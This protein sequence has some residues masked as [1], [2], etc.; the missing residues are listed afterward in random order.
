MIKYSKVNRPFKTIII[1]KKI[2]LIC[3]LFVI[4]QMAG[5]G[6]EQEKFEEERDER[7]KNSFLNS[8]RNP[9]TGEVDY[10]SVREVHSFIDKKISE[11]TKNARVSAAMPYIEWQERGPNNFAGRIQKV[12][13]DPNDPLKKKVWAGSNS[14]GLFYN[15]DIENVNSGWVATNMHDGPM[16]IIDMTFDPSN[17]QIFYVICVGG[18]YKSVDA[19]QTWSL[20]NS[21]YRGYDLLV[22]NSTEIYQATNNGLLK[23]IDGG[24]NWTIVLKPSLSIGGTFTGT[25][26]GGVNATSIERG[27][28]GTLYAAF[29]CG[30]IFK[31]SNGTVWTNILAPDNPSNGA[32]TLIAL[33]PSTSG[34]SQILYVVCGKDN[35]TG[36]FRKSTDG[37]VNWTPKTWTIG[38]Y[39]LYDNLV[40]KVHPTNP[41]TVFA[42][43]N[44]LR[45][46]LNGGDTWV[47]G[48]GTISVAGPVTQADWHDIQ[49]NPIDPSKSVI[50]NDQGVAFMQG[51]NNNSSFSGAV[52]YKNF[53]ASQV[54]WGAMRQV[55]ND[56]IFGAATQ[57][58]PSKILRGSGIGV[59]TN[60]SINEGNYIKFDDDQPNL[61]L[62]TSMINVE[63]YL[64][65]LNFS[66][67]NTCLTCGQGWAS[68]GVCRDYD[69]QSN[70][71]YG[72]LGFDPNVAGRIR[73]RKV[74]N[75]S[76]SLNSTTN[77]VSDFYIDGIFAN[78]GVSSLID[79][80]LLSLPITIKLGKTA[81]TMFISGYSPANA[82]GILYK[83]TNFTSSTPTVTRISPLTPVNTRF[84]GSPK[85]IAIG[86]TDN[87]LLITLNDN[88][89]YIETL[90]YTNDGGASWKTLK[91]MSGNNT[92]TGLPGKFGANYA[93]FNPFNYNQVILATNVGIWTCDDISLTIP[94]W[95][96]TNAKF[97]KIPTNNIEIRPSDGTIMVST[98]GRGIFTA[99][100]NTCQNDVVRND[101][102]DGGVLTIP[103]RTYIR[104]VGGNRIETNGIVNYNANTYVDLLPNFEV[105]KNGI[106]KAQIGGCN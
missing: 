100:L 63:L 80:D 24:T 70:T 53:L 101:V 16:G 56:T 42:G 45:L 72:L 46:S 65:N 51:T 52:R 19:G 97:G 93:A 18:F 26:S 76:A 102:I 98:Y 7:V 10:E 14:T 66:N 2:I 69:S 61:M 31:S 55:A 37:G 15:N 71:M 20:K 99:K 36:W 1:M 68:G 90:F 74:A 34:T 47:A 40:I 85:C 13:Y 21:A 96:I 59:A 54:H 28:D 103:S 17:T 8:F 67:S 95:E 73:L 49:F 94:R 57:D 5:F 9:A 62:Y 44:S 22:V 106:F 60:L 30:Q 86:V 27:T 105:K 43:V 41:N 78:D 3:Y 87:Q 48:L 33:A 88:S 104:G 75:I 58:Q 35:N 79:Y 82:G 81:N 83:V 77:V 38:F 50:S 39:Q 29:G 6:Q 23:S 11:N 84:Q 4:S 89:S 25:V 91:K 12:M 92:L 32:S 64:A